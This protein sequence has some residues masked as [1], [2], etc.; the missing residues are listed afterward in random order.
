MKILWLF[1]RQRSVQTT[2]L[3]GLY[4]LFAKFLPLDVH[5]GFYTFSLLIKDILLLLLPLTVGLFIAHAVSSFEKKAP[6]FILTIVLFE[7]ISNSLSVWYAF[8]SAHFA[9]KY[10]SNLVPLRIDEHFYPLWRLQLEKPIWW[11]AEKGTIAGM[12]IGLL[13]S[14]YLPKAKKN[15]LKGK[16]FAEWV[17]TRIFSKLIP[18]FILGFVARMVQLNILEQIAVQYA[19]LVGIL[20]V[21]LV[22]YI[23]GLFLIGS[24]FSWKKFYESLKNI[25]PA[26]G[27]AFS[28]GC[29]LST[30]PWTIE[31]T[32]KNLQNK[33]LAKVV[34]PATTNIQ[35]IGDC[36]VNTFLC[37][38]IY[39][40]FYGTVPSFSTWLT[41][42][43]VFV[44]ARFATAAVLGGAIFIMLPIY[45]YYLGFTAEMLA[46]ILAFNVV[47]DPLITSSNVVANGALCQIFEK[48]WLAISTDKKMPIQNR[49]MD[50]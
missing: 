34:I 43:L 8:G 41:F 4:F 11:S 28:S 30:M 42:S 29:S 2:V 37:F 7:L 49:N 26:A 40:F 36:I 27:I 13:I 10:I 17:L 33:E 47:L 38:V 25:A 35:Q 23:G 45:E 32:A 19:D 15:L 31:G 44:L 16:E 18:F 20:I 14:F 46:V 48:V 39:T 50:T 3:L 24:G 5:R 9:V 22:L 12:V 6:Y 1:L 21:L